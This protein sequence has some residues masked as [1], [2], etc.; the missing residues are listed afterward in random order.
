MSKDTQIK[1][2]SALVETCFDKLSKYNNA[3]EEFEK[4]KKHA[5]SSS[6]KST[7]GATIL[8]NSQ[9]LQTDGEN[10]QE[11]AIITPPPLDNF[12]LPPPDNSDND[13]DDN[14]KFSIFRN[15]I[16]SKLGLNRN[17]QDEENDD[18]IKSKRKERLGNQAKEIAQQLLRRYNHHFASLETFFTAYMTKLEQRYTKNTNFPP[19]WENTDIPMHPETEQQLVAAFDQYSSTVL[20]VDGIYWRA[21]S[22]RQH[23]FYV[24]KNGKWF[25]EG[26][27]RIQARAFDYLAQYDRII[28]LAPEGTSG[29]VLMPLKMREKAQAKRKEKNV[30]NLFCVNPKNLDT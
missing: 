12:P 11:A 4:R 30:K 20:A 21:D 26:I 2:L 16:L 17:M 10:I 23:S 19:V 25:I 9:Q 28:A 24:K 6:T 8:K 5:S 7:T 29:V 1:R 14:R 22:L 27:N 13:A 3:S 18:T 15:S